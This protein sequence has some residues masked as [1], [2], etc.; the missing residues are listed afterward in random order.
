MW[1]LEWGS[2]GLLKSVMVL[3]WDRNLPG[4]GG[5]CS[6]FCILRQV[7]AKGRHILHRELSVGEGQEL[8]GGELS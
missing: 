5:N 8:V 1:A 2:L 6:E 4:A 7:G 3:A